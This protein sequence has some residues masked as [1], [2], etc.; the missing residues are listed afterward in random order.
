ML[1]ILLIIII[2]LLVII[3]ITISFNRWKDSGGEF[4]DA[5]NTPIGLTEEQKRKV[6]TEA[7]FN[8]DYLNKE[9]NEKNL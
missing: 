4:R 8:P 7:G 1:Y 2:V 5:F 6:M 3:W 9:T